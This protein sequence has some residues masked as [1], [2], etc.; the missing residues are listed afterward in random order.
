MLFNYTAVDTSGH[1]TSGGIEAVNQEV[2]IASLQRRGLIISSIVS[3]DKG[4]GLDCV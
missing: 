1:P 2:A 3:A 4:E